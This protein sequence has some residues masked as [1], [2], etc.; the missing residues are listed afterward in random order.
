M[1]SQSNPLTDIPAPSFKPNGKPVTP[2]IS[3]PEHVR[4]LHQQNWEAD[5]NN[6]LARAWVQAMLEGRPP[7]DPA[8]MKAAGLAGCSNIN[9]LDGQL[10]IRQKMIPYVQVLQSLPTFLNIRTNYGTQ[11]QRVGWERKMSQAHAQVLREWRQFVPRYLFNLLYLASHGVGFC[12]FTDAMDWRWHVSTLGEMVIPRLSR[13]DAS[14]FQVISTRKEFTPYELWSKIRNNPKDKGWTREKDQGWNVGAT[15]L[16]ME[17][18]TGEIFFRGND[19][20]QDERIWKGNEF[21]FT[22]TAKTCA[23]ILMWIEE[24]DGRVTQLIS[25]EEACTSGRQDKENFLFREYGYFNHMEEGMIV[26]TRDIGT[27]GYFHSIRGTGSDIMPMVQQMNR[28]KNNMADALEVESAIPVTATEE[29]LAS[30]LFYTKAGPFMPLYP[31]MELKDRDTRNYSNSV[32]PGMEMFNRN[33]LEQTGQ[34]PPGLPSGANIDPEGLLGALSGIDIMEGTLFAFPWQDLLRA[35][36][37]RLIRIKSSAEPGGK[38]AFRFRKL[39]L[40]AG[41]PMEAIDKIDV[42]RTT[43]TRAIGNGSPQSQLFTSNAIKEVVPMLDET[44]KNKWLRNYLASLP[45]MSWEQVDDL[46]PEIPD[47][48]PDQQVRNAIFENNLLT[49]GGQCPVLPNDDHLAHIEEHLKPM[50]EIV[51]SVEQGMPKDEAVQPLYPLWMHTNE[52]LEAVEQ[53]QVNQQEV[54][55]ARQALQSMG[56]IIVNGQ[57][58]AEAKQQ[59]A[60]EN[61]EKGLDPDGN[62]LPDGGGMVNGERPIFDGLTATEMAKLTEARIKL[63]QAGRSAQIRDQQHAMSMALKQQEMTDKAAAA[64]QGRVLADYKTGQQIRGMQEGINLKKRAAQE[65]SRQAKPTKKPRSK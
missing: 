49:T 7:N 60:M 29:L 18:A 4:S 17:K 39:C 54:S 38:E 42:Q 46:A 50:G 1:I 43:A 40:D 15:K 31:G 59:K 32:F 57:R 25:S 2:L 62:P 36:L 16:K 35:S 48:R 26:F 28:M 5:S 33:F 9:W 53:D 61:A 20:E 37:G 45:G 55:A 34:L 24:T 58:E 65:K 8:L 44:G 56:E 6:R 23:C 22:R 11:T 30:E 12:Y 21:Y 41:V 52:H 51:Q 13:S 14:Q 19:W 64:K 63:E 27:N 47:M 10:A 3:T